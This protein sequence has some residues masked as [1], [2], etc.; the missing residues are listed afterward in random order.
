MRTVATIER[1]ETLESHLDTSL[2]ATTGQLETELRATATRLETL[3]TH[4]DTRLNATT[5]R[6]DT[7]QSSVATTEQLVA[8][9]NTVS[10]RLDTL[11]THL[12]TRLDALFENITS[13]HQQLLGRFPTNPADSCSNILTR[14]PSSP[15]GY[16]WIE[17]PGQLSKRQYCDMTLSCGGVTGG[18]T[19]VTKLDMT[20]SSH[21]CPTGL[22]QITL[23]GKRTCGITS[24]SRSCSS[25]AYP[26]DILRYSKICGRIRGYQIGSTDAFAFFPH[27][28][29]SINDYYV[30]GVSLTHGN[31][32][33][34]I[35]TFASAV[36]E[37]NIYP[38][39][40]CSCQDGS[41]T[42]P[43][44]FVGND[45][46]CDTGSADSFQFGTFYGDDPLW[47]GAGC[48][49][50]NMCCSFNNPP[51]FYKQLPQ[52]TSDNIEMRV[53]RDQ[54]RKDE[55]VA[56]DIIDIYVQ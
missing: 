6:L 8:E 17:A 11:Q 37:V 47:D 20:I 45:Y 33:H 7:L 40:K 53:C 25:V 42:T 21:Q 52:S 35:W 3:Q 39:S 32:R 56:V 38:G 28:N 2:N 27:S 50:S 36:H 22:R 12:D 26:M 23:S 55:D 49:S 43:P 5:E 48:G 54:D 4:F 15:S 51:W 1:L 34:H 41:S 19:Q 16:Y 14:N 29:P 24:D 18:W 10:T 46:F 30:D 13:L 44:A 9:L 31:P